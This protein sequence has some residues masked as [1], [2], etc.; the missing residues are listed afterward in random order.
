MGRANAVLQH[1]PRQPET[2]LRP[3]DVAHRP[4]QRGPWLSALH[5]AEYLDCPSIQAFYM[6]Y[7]RHRIVPAKR[8]RSL[9][10]ARA[11]LDRAIGLRRRSL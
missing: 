7:R 5:A 6:W 3:L 4:D 1:H 10:F 2:G 8:G 9:L 11:D